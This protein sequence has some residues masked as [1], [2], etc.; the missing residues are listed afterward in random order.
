MDSSQP[1][2][3]IRD[4]Y[5]N[6]KKYYTDNNDDESEIYIRKNFD[7][8][9]SNLDNLIEL[10][11]EY[12]IQEENK[13]DLL[14][15]LRY[16]NTFG[17]TDKTIDKFLK[18]F[19]DYKKC[20]ES[21]KNGSINID[22]FKDITEIQNKI[23]FLIFIFKNINKDYETRLEY[24]ISLV[25][26]LLLKTIYQVNNTDVLSIGI[27]DIFYINKII[28]CLVNHISLE[29]QIEILEKREHITYMSIQ[30]TI[31]LFNNNKEAIIDILNTKNTANSFNDNIKTIINLL[32][33]SKLI[34]NYIID[35]KSNS[36]I[37]ISNN[38]LTT[39][40]LSI[41]LEEIKSSKSKLTL[42][43]FNKFRE[44][45]IIADRI[46]ELAFR[47]LYQLF[48]KDFYYTTKLKDY[49][50][51]NFNTKLDKINSGSKDTYTYTSQYLGRERTID[52]A[53]GG[54]NKKKTRKLK[55][56]IP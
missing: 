47:D 52:V 31:G 8:Y 7:S 40:F 45:K 55:K 28:A 44:R 1:G 38:E 56:Y 10:I 54:E 3:N 23:D 2:D 17:E 4:L 26:L 9:K 36:H 41:K 24:Y 21:L 49:I 20:V 27:N 33:N 42:L 6:L 39:E 22:T 13:K 25:Y 50:Q 19:E 11:N 37:T 29:K 16:F 30:P 51:S 48:E 12:N 5:D 14:I 53:F 46:I 35:N 34:N 43:A 15:I 18:L 32:S